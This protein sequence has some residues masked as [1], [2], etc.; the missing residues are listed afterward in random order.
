MGMVAIFF[1]LSCADFPTVA[2]LVKGQAINHPLTQVVLTS[3]LS[4]SRSQSTDPSIDAFWARFKSAVI[5]SDKNAVANLSQFPIQMP[6]GVAS[7]RTR[8]QLV[9][10]YRELF[11]VQA[12]A[13]EC[14]AESKPTIDANNRN[15]FEVGCKDAA[16]NEVVVYGFVRTKTGWKLKSL[17][18]INE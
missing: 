1:V 18:N 7:I 5:S 6:Y 13:Q 16:G 9:R 10:R 2:S 11:N 4:R 8:S 14:F 15:R 17:D 3:L 12:N